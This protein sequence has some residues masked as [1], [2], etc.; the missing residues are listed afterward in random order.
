MICWCVAEYIFFVQVSVVGGGPGGVYS[1]YRYDIV[2]TRPGLQDP[3]LL[4][5]SKTIHPITAEY[6]KDIICIDLYLLSDNEL[7]FVR[8]LPSYAHE[9]DEHHNKPCCHAPVIHKSHPCRLLETNATLNGRPHASLFSLHHR[10][11]IA[12][13]CSKCLQ[14]IQV[15]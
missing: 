4:L 14:G 1:A 8:F 12:I 10:S 15:I 7:A 3:L 6:A 2:V 11:K 9:H 5:L 13:R